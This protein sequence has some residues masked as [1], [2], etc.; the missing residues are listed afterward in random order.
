MEEERLKEIIRRA[1]A[2]AKRPP[3]GALH[4]SEEGEEPR[5]LEIDFQDKQDWRTLD[6]AFLVQ[7]PAGYGS[8]LSFFSDEAL[9][10]FLPAYLIA[11]LEGK[12]D[13]V[14]VADRLSGPFTDEARNTPVNPRRYGGLTVFDAARQRFS[15]FT[16]EEVTAIVAY[17]EY[18][19]ASD[20]FERETIRQALA[21]YWKPRLAGGS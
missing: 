12:L 18:K 3:S 16:P 14:D 7:A 6:P 9:R 8:A 4:R 13:H 15:G 11:D 2:T 5:L 19:A 10:Y 20:E 1:F 21:N 17:L